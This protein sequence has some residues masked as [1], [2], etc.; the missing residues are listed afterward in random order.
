[1]LIVTTMELVNTPPEGAMIGADH[2]RMRAQVIVMEPEL[3]L[4]NYASNVQRQDMVA[5]LK[6]LLKSFRIEGNQ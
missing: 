1:M 3:E 2:S 5:M 6:A 4:F